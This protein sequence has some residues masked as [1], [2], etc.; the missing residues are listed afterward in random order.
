MKR[1]EVIRQ[2]LLWESIAAAAQAKA[3]RLRDELNTEA[4]AEF[5]THGTAP[6]WRP[7][8]L[9]TVT[10]PVSRDTVFVSDAN[11]LLQWVVKRHPTEVE[12]IRQV[13]P[14]FVVA[15]L[16]SVDHDGRNVVSPDGSGEIVP[17]LA[18]RAGGRPG[19]LSFR[20]TSHAR[21][22]LAAAAE[23]VVDRID[24]EAPVVLEPVEPGAT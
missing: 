18:V 12:R 19:A 15:L 10:L 7:P 20:P 6:T 21:S 8:D 1:F 24:I 17:G 3:A 14:G 22:I 9:A 4:L 5:E 13:R 11:A 23:A 2:T 16:A